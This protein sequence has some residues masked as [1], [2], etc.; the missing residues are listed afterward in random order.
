VDRIAQ[1][2]D[3]QGDERSR[4]GPITVTVSPLTTLLAV[5]AASVAPGLRISELRVLVALIEHYRRDTGQCDPS[6]DRI[7]RLLSITRRTVFRALD[8]LAAGG[9]VIRIRHGGHWNCNQYEP[10]WGRLLQ[11]EQEWSARLWK[12]ART[13]HAQA[14]VSTRAARHLNGDGRVTQ[15]YLTNLKQEAGGKAKRVQPQ[16]VK[17]R[18]TSGEALKTVTMKLVMDDI[19]RRFSRDVNVYGMVI[20]WIK[21]DLIEKAVSAERQRRG[22]GIDC[23]IDALQLA[24]IHTEARGSSDGISDAGNS[25]RGQ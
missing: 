3:G 10:A 7:A 8:H 22:G 14:S 4:Q 1:G 12:G 20:S 24:G 6:I 19:H 17:P 25:D 16:P 13:R 23:I 21:D 5:K 11:V 15:T 2:S 18:I 9:L